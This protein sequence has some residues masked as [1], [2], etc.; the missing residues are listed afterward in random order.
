M[1]LAHIPSNKKNH[2]Q[3]NHPL[4]KFSSAPPCVAGSPNHATPGTVRSRI[5]IVFAAAILLAL[6]GCSQKAQEIAQPERQVPEAAP[7]ENVAIEKTPEAAPALEVPLATHLDDAL[8]INQIQVIA[9]HNSYHAMAPPQLLELV[10]QVYPDAVTWEYDHAPLDTQLNRG[11]RSFEFDIHHTDK[12]YEV[13]HVQDFDAASTC[14]DFVGCLQV[15]RRWS[16]AHPR[17]VPIISL[18]ELKKED[19]PQASTQTY[20]FEAEDLDALDAELLS[21]FSRDELITPDDV[22]GEYATLSEAV[23]A[24][25]WPTLAQAR[26][27]CMFVLH[28]GGIHAENYTKNAPSCEG[29]PMFMQGSGGKPYDA[30]FVDNNPRDPQV[31]QHVKEGFIV[32]TR[33]DANLKEGHANDTARR[34]TALASGAHIVSTD[35]PLGET[36]PETGYMVQLPGGVA[37]RPNP[38]TAP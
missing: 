21:V 32:R 33:A 20:A 36:H 12:G 5:L 26:G 37:A 28:T 17:H 31:T 1:T 25:N 22:R 11:I 30:V 23:K 18:L 3:K 16:K 35:F 15:I 9:T 8:R 13:F 29:R 2:L 7:A 14:P 4:S 24:D 6:M 10:K 34:D 38:I 19:V 27:K